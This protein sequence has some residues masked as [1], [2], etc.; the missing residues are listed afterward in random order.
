ML[1]AALIAAAVV[2][3]AAWRIDLEFHPF[4]QCRKCDGSGRNK[5]SRKKAYGLC[6][7]GSRRPRFAA[8]AAAARQEL[9]KGK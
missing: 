6:R 8:K 7:H 9:R 4:T 5:G 3:F 2:A 1:I